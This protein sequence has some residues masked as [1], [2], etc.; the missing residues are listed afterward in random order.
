MQ[1]E[2]WE[3]EF[4]SKVIPTLDPY[5][6]C[7]QSHVGRVWLPCGTQGS[8]HV[9]LVEQVGPWMGLF[10]PMP[11]YLTVLL[12]NSKWWGA[13][14]WLTKTKWWASGVLRL[15]SRVSW[16]KCQTGAARCLWHE[17]GIHTN[18]APADVDRFQCKEN[19]IESN[20]LSHISKTPVTEASGICV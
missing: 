15:E 3:G 19:R 14:P 11:L 6:S 13:V 5:Q 18:P 9:D 17:E 4:V 10:N 16:V 8:A 7:K 1:K 20:L 12:F 2:E